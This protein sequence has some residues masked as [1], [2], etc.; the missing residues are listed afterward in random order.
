VAEKVQVKGEEP[1]RTKVFRQWKGVNT[2]AARNAIPDDTWYH[3]ENMQSIGDANVHSVPN[4]S[5]ALHDYASD[6]IYWSQYVNVGG[7]DYL[8]SFSTGGKCFSWNIGSSTS[9][10]IASGLAGSGTRV[11]QW[12]NTDALFVDSTGYYYWDGTTFAAISGT[13]VP[14]SG[15]DIAVA[16]GRVWI[17]QGRLLTFSAANDYTATGFLAANGAGSQA[18]TDPTLRN[19]V[20]RLSAQN[21]YLYIIG[22]TSINAISDVYV[23]SGASPPT[24]VY[25]NLNIQAIIGSDQPGSVFALNQ[26]LMFANRYGAWALYG[27]NAKKISS[28][29]DG[30]WQYLDFTKLISGGQCVVNNILCA[31]FLV[32]RLNDPVFGSNT[33]IAMFH[34]DKWFFANYGTLTFITSAVANNIPVLF[35]FLG[36]KLYQ[37]FSDTTTAPATKLITPLWP[38]DD[39]LAD[40]QVIRAGFEVTV[41]SFA[42]TFAMT[43]DTVNSQY[44]AVSLTNGGNVAWQNNAG[45]ITQWQNNTPVVV[46]WFSA[47]YLLYNASAPGTYGKYVGLTI[48]ASGSAYQ[49]SATDMDYKLGARW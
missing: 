8:L 26:A 15:T 24:P 3:L 11:A 42:G 10:Q 32:K 18:L 20:V 43:V 23:P 21:G 34:D 22:S 30:T 46:N 38:M 36:N 49:F 4:I 39:N 16:F 47:A 6:T 9:A 12:K 40:K 25:T 14:T 37:L 27:T 28:D 2:R 45:T 13:G 19:T 33:V 7:N 1:I 5:A 17:V 31:G 29:I 48:S 44:A 41:S 35:G